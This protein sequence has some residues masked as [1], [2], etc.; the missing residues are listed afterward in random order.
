[1][2]AL[3]FL[4]LYLELALIRWVTG[5]VHNFG[6]FTNF[7]MLAAFLGIGVGCLLGRRM[8]AIA[9]LPSI[10]VALAL[11]VRVAQLQIDLPSKSPTAV[12]W[13]EAMAAETK[14]PVAAAVLVLF[15]LISA[16]FLGLGQI[17][18]ELFAELP[19]LRAYGFNVLGGLA[20]S[21]CSRSTRTSIIRRSSGSR[22]RSSSRS[23]SSSARRRGGRYG[24]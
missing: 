4:V 8:S 9:L 20:G 1:M 7:A 5:Y 23:R 16:V 3:S 13:S 6:Y 17:L 22:L 11:I 19:R 15:V 21:S 2:V 12:F 18:G 10:L 14:A 24:R